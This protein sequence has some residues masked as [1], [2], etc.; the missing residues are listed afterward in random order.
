MPTK[1]ACYMRMSSDDQ[2]A[3]IELQELAIRHHALC[4][5]MEIVASY[6]DEGRSG[7]TLTGR[8][9]MQQLL[10]DVM[11]D[12]CP[13]SVVLVLDVSRWG[14]FQ[15]VDEAAYYEFHCKK[16]GVR[17]DYVA[18]P[19]LPKQTPFS[20]ILKQLKRAMAGEYSREL[21]VKTRAGI[22]NVVMSGYAAG[23][24]PCFGYRRMAFS[25]IGQ[26]KRLLEP[27]ERKP[28]VTDKVKWV[29]G[30]SHEVE[31]V[32]KVFETYLA[33]TAITE[34]AKQLNANGIKS[35][36]GKTITPRMIQALL[37]NE[38][39]TGVFSWGGRDRQPPSKTD[40]ARLEQPAR[41]SGMMPS[42]VNRSTWQRVQE[43]F[44]KRR[45]GNRQNKRSP[46]ERLIARRLRRQAYEG[47]SAWAAA[48]QLRRRF[49]RDVHTLCECHGV[50][51]KLFAKEGLVQVGLQ[52]VR[53]R[54]AKEFTSVSGRY[55][56]LQ[57][58]QQFWAPGQWLLVMRMEAGTQTGR[59][60]YLL[61]PHIHK[62]FQGYFYG[63][64][65]I[66][67][68]RYRLDCKEALLHALHELS[69]TK[70]ARQFNHDQSES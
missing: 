21:G 56:Y 53:I 59:D 54:T 64:N 67:Y 17:V 6:V 32:A 45:T 68:S 36:D 70:I 31:A 7:V 26:A 65:C 46:V 8:S 20:S 5:D 41:N 58:V 3:S 60:F 61:P 33:G 1:A 55:W 11:E 63:E 62:D 18:E 49:V 23:H 50:P 35:H 47:K 42:I 69:M 57:H 24:L 12:T 39:V 40:I 9:Q 52:P 34:I 43:S 4:H 28:V 66:D 14:R 10:R 37:R 30:P 22:V 19:F 27:S 25:S 44:E 38:I 15:D 16:N 2:A 13:F 51:A 29:L 48:V